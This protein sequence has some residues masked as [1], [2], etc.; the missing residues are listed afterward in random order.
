MLNIRTWLEEKAEKNASRQALVFQDLV[1][2]YQELNDQ[3][4]KVANALA[5]LGIG[6][7]EKVAIL[8]PNGP[9]YI[10]IWFALAKLGAVAACV[11]LSFRGEGLRFLVDS[12]DARYVVVD[13][14][15]APIYISLRAGLNKVQTTI[16]F[17]DLPE[18]E[19]SK[20]DFSYRTFLAAGQVKP[21]PEME[22]KLSDP[23]TFLHTSGTTGRPKWCI[24]SQGYYLEQGQTYADTYGFCSRDRI[25]NPLPL[26]H[27]NPQVYLVM[28]SL[29]VN[30]TMIMEERFS[31]SAFWEQ[32]RK[33]QANVAILHMAPLEF[34]KKQPYHPD[35]KNHSLRFVFPA[36]R[37]F[38][39]RF[40]VGLAGGGYGLTEA[41]LVVFQK[42][43]FPLT[44]KYA[45]QDRIRRFCGKP[46]ANVE[47]AILD[48]E[49]RQA[50]P[51][52]TGEIAIRPRRPN[53][54]FSGYYEKND[55]TVECWRNLWFHTGDL[56][57]LDADGE[58]NF[59]RR[60]SE[61]LNVKGEWVDVMGLEDLLRS[62]PQVLDAAVVGIPD[63]VEG[64][65]IK[66]CIQPK[67]GEVVRPE[68]LLDFCQR[69]IA[70]YMIPHYIE[71]MEELPRLGG[72]EKVAK[73]DMERAGIS[74]KVWDREKAGY[75]IKRL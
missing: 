57:F 17:P 45:N 4:N 30:A 56:G 38:M 68:D 55:R 5:W 15:M 22:I 21:P 71:F 62:H 75:K 1:V 51:G 33:Y 14:A 25:F 50:A 73:A 61:S 40:G 54:I 29:C 20:E 23:W 28:G 26:Y 6:R 52:I 44:G 42:F 34:L 19:T 24:L 49:D 35:E 16:W 11:N 27:A 70:H 3:I 2:T 43:P 13:Q 37:E 46:S 63:P 9:E 72:T 10:Y 8:L 7:G 64:K 12:C 67:T 47:I 53:V 66:A 36:D 18:E 41:A 31:A 65:R 59:V 58:L 32:V 60:A 39:E 69:K 48:E 74:D